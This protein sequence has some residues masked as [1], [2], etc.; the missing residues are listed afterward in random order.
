MPNF[1]TITIA[2]GK[3]TPLNHAFSPLRN[4]AGSAEWAEPSA[5]GSLTKRNGLVITQKL[6]GKG[7]STVLNQAELVLP[8]IVSETVEGV[9]TDV[10]Q[11]NVRVVVQLICD[12]RV[13]KQNRVDGRVLMKNLLL[14]AD[15][16]AAFDDVTAFS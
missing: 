6:P 16:A 1:Q 12:P 11:S 15:V 5:D 10:V 3:T 13:P 14:N 4:P 8:Y 2:D 7:R 9:V